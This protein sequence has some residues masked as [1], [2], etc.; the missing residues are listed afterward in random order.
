MSDVKVYIK[1][2]SP[3]AERVGMPR[4]QTPGAAGFDL[5]VPEQISIVASQTIVIPLGF[6]MEIPPGYEMQIRPRSSVVLDGELDVKFGTI[7]SDYRG[8]IALIVRNLNRSYGM[9]IQAGDRL[10]QG[11]IC[12]VARAELVAVDDLSPTSRGEGGFGSTGK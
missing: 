1:F 11:I 12:P 3:E 10:A 9:W 4:Y 2:L 6:A 7:D 5:A 8:E